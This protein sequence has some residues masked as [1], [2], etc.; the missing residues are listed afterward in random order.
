MRFVLSGDYLAVLKQDFDVKT[1]Y[2]LSSTTGKVLWHTD[3]K[4]PQSPQPMHSLVIREAKLYGI[5]PHAGQGF[6]VAG[7]DCQTGRPLF[8]PFEQKGYGG[9]PEVTLFPAVFGNAIV[10]KIKDRQDYEVRAFDA[11]SGRLLHVMKVKSAGDFG[12]HGRVSAAVQNGKLL[13]LGKND[14]R[15]GVGK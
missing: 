7:L 14:L 11:A 4:D 12:E 5:K 10:A 6:F 13:L 15:T 8:A 2:M 9:K 3:P 1:L